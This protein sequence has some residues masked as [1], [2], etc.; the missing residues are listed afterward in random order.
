MKRM[1]ATLFM[2]ALCSGCLGDPCDDAW[3]PDFKRGLVC[4]DTPARCAQL[5]TQA[6]RTVGFAVALATTDAAGKP[7]SASALKHRASCVAEFMGQRGIAGVTVAP[8][9]TAVFATTTFRRVAPALEFTV[10]RD[11]TANCNG[12]GA[13]ASCAAIAASACKA[14]AFC[15]SITA[16]PVEPTLQCLQAPAVVGCQAAGV[17]CDGS[18]TW[19]TS[20]AGACH[21]FPS[22]CLPAGW[23]A[24]AA[25]CSAA[26][27]ACM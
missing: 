11:F 7:V 22:T 6:D 25:P 2:T 20:P 17:G 15:Q 1:L 19:A 5:Q 4:A 26:Q 13:C 9:N 8:D 23:V 27:Q 14:D 16:S 18:L 3:E 21:L 12:A 24:A 10:V